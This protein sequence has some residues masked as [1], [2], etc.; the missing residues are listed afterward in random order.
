M[1]TRISLA[2]FEAYS[3]YKLVFIGL[4]C[5]LIPLGVVFG[6]FAFFG[7]NT[8]HWNGQPIHGVTGLLVSPL[9]GA[10]LAIGF[11][12]FAGTACAFGLWL[13]SKF[14]PLSLWGKN[15]EHHVENVT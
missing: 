10:I 11:T 7:A 1:F 9:I 5:S 12:A 14:K 13:F 3:V 8:I 2:R 6:I 15:V 4:A